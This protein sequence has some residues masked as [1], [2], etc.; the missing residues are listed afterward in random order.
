MF[1]Q[2]AFPT[3]PYFN[4]YRLFDDMLTRGKKFLSRKLDPMPICVEKK[5]KAAEPNY[6]C[7]DLLAFGY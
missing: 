4:I 6:F 7:T 1:Q 3:Q 5:I 2:N